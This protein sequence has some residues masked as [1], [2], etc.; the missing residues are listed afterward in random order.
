MDH[1]GSVFYYRAGFAMGLFEYNLSVG[2][3]LFSV[4][5]D[6]HTVHG[7]PASE[8]KGASL[9]RLSGDYFSVYSPP[10]EKI[11]HAMNP[12]PY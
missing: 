10:Q 11:A 6:R 5:G 3:A 2:H 9:C 1:L 7:K 12:R 8:I 4:K